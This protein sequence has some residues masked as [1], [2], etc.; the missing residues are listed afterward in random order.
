[1]EAFPPETFLPK[2]QMR[3]DVDLRQVPRK[4]EM[5]RRRRMYISLKI[6][7]ILEAEGIKP[8]DLLPPQRIY[9]LLSS[10]DKHDLY[11]PANYLPLEIFD[12]EEYDCRCEIRYYAIFGF[13]VWKG[14]Y[15]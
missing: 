7:D 2:V 10:E 3:Y 12:D 14:R 5:E 11:T 1:M 6:E 8:Y 13:A 15:F 9:P 4:V